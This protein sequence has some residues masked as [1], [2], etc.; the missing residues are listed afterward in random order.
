MTEIARANGIRV[1]LASV[2]PVD[3][4]PWKR[5]L[6]PAPK[7][8]ALNAWMKQYA[9]EHGAVFLDFHSAMQNE[10]HGLRLELTYDGVHLTEA[11]YRFMTPLAERAIAEALR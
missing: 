3:D 2:L 5:G 11:G 6:D 7:I 1:V 8:L 4:Y 10:R 9:A